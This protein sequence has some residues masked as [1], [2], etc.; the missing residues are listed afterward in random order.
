[1]LMHLQKNA[2]QWTKT[3][4]ESETPA[5]CTDSTVTPACSSSTPTG[6]S[7]AASVRPTETTEQES[8]DST[9]TT[10]GASGDNDGADHKG[11]VEPVR[12]SL[13]HP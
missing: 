5:E 3:T 4:S 6:G 1:M 2:L 11:T 12:V 9:E 13:S 7:A 8:C 10:A